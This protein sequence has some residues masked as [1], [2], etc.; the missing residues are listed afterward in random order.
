VEPGPV[1]T[2]AEKRAYYRWLAG[3]VTNLLPKEPGS[4]NRFAMIVFSEDGKPQFVGRGN[5]IDA[6]RALR[7]MAYRLERKEVSEVAS[8]FPV[9]KT[10]DQSTVATAPIPVPCL[11]S[12]NDPEGWEFFGPMPTEVR[13]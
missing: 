1:K 5:R 8:S 2:D 6:I 10:P 7:E 13:G 12:P 11:P 3:Q 9:N 4:R